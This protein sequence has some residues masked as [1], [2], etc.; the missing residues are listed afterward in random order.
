MYP[1]SARDGGGA[2]CPSS[3][4]ARGH[5]PSPTWR[6]S[7]P[8]RRRRRWTLVQWLLPPLLLLLL[9]CTPVAD[10]GRASRAAQRARHRS[11]RW[12]TGPWLPCVLEDGDCG[13]GWQGRSVRCVDARGHAVLERHCHRHVRPR[14]VQSCHTECDDGSGAAHRQSLRWQAGEWSACEE[15]NG[16]P[17]LRSQ[18]RPEARDAEGLA[19]RNVSCVFEPEA[20]SPRVVDAAACMHLLQPPSEMP[21][22]ISCP[23]DCV[24]TPFEAWPACHNVSG[25]ASCKADSVVRRRVVLVGPSNGG[26]ECPALSETKKCPARPGCR[27]WRKRKSRRK[28]PAADYVLRVGPWGECQSDYSILQRESLGSQDGSE[29]PVASRQAQLG[30]RRRKV[31]CLDGNG[32]LVDIG[33]CRQSDG[34][35]RPLPHD[36]ESCVV[37]VH[38]TVSPWS[39]WH[40][41]REGCQLDSGETWHGGQRLR[42]RMRYVQQLPYGAGRPCPPLVETALQQDRLPLCSSFNWAT[43]EWNACVPVPGTHCNGGTRHRNVTCV[44]TKDW[45]PVSSQLCSPQ[46]RPPLQ[47]ECRVPCPIDCEV[48]HWSPWGQCLPLIRGS[49]FPAPE[50][51]YRVRTRT[52]LTAPS[53]GGR[54]C[55]HLKEVESCDRA[56][57]SHWEPQPWGPCKPLSGGNCGD[58]IQMRDASC[59]FFDGTV[60]DDAHCIIY[61]SPIM[62]ERECTVPCADDCV[63]SDWSPWSPCSSPCAERMDYGIQ[64]RNRSILGHAGKGGASCPAKSDLREV[65]DCN[66]VR[67]FGM[68]WRTGP[69]KKCVAENVT[70]G[71]GRGRQNRTVNCFFK[72][73]VSD[74]KCAPLKKPANSQPCHIPCPVDCQVT[75]FSDWRLCKDCG[76]GAEPVLVRERFVLRRETPGGQPCPWQSLREVRLCRPTDGEAWCLLG[77]NSQLGR[78]PYRWSTSPWSQCVFAPDA[79]CGSGHQVRNVTCLD[80]NSI[81]VEPALCINLTSVVVSSRAPVLSAPAAHRVCH[82]RCHDQCAVSEWSPWSPCPEGDSANACD[83]DA[84]SRRTRQFIGVSSP[85]CLVSLTEERPCPPKQSVKVIN[86]PWS[87]CILQGEASCGTGYRLR[88]TSATAHACG[89]TGF[90]NV[91]CKEP[92]PVDCVM[93]EWSPWSRCDAV[94]GGGTRTRTRRV[95]RWHQY[96]GRPCPV[97]APNDMEIQTGTC[98]MDCGRNIWLP[99]GWTRC[100]PLNMSKKLPCGVEGFRTRS[101]LC[102]SVLNGDPYEELT[103]EECDPLRKPHD[104]EP[105]K[106]H[107]PGE[108]VVSEWSEWSSCLDPTTGAN[109]TERNRTRRVLRSQKHGRHCPY[110][111]VETDVCLKH[112]WELGAQGSCVVS[113]GSPCGGGVSKTPLYCVRDSDGLRVDYNYCDPKTKPS[114]K[115]L[116][117]PC[118][119]SCPI[120]CKVS[121]WSEWDQTECESCGTFVLVPGEQVRHRE[122]IQ[123]ATDSGRPCARSLTQRKPCAFTPCYYWSSGG[124]SQCE[125]HGADCGFGVRKRDVTCR[126]SDGV[127]VDNSFC[128][129]ANFT[130][131][132]GGLLGLDWLVVGNDVQTEEQCYVPCPQGCSLFPWSDWSPCNRNCDTG[133]ILGQTS[134]SRAVMTPSKTGESRY[135]PLEMVQTRPCWDG[136]CLTYSWRV[137]NGTLQCSRSDGL[138][139]E[140][141]GCAGRPRPCVPGCPAGARCDALTG[142]CSCLRG[143]VPVFVGPEDGAPL[144]SQ[145]QRETESSPSAAGGASGAGGGG[146]GVVVLGGGASSSAGAGAA[147]GSTLLARCEPI[148]TTMDGAGHAADNHTAAAAGD[149]LLKYYPDDNEYSFWMYAMISV[150]SA[151]VIFVAVTVYLMCHSSMRQR[152]KMSYSF[153]S[154]HRSNSSAASTG[155]VARSNA[156]CA[157]EPAPTSSSC[158][159][160]STT[161][162]Y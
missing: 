30:V 29:L 126:R 90:E 108:C 152:L 18:C 124:W 74:K 121:D 17:H 60:V 62:K 83:K 38:C 132:A 63:L 87:D 40:L 114:T 112:H 51:G 54:E 86:A 34:K 81:P 24:V 75:N 109:I 99:S 16:R 127:L 153:S 43:S 21:C 95:V 71:C 57:L 73:S 36:A 49:P 136:V 155:M 161:Q 5:A 134:R 143:T 76:D 58:G 100:R 31:A 106:L 102:M 147:G 118:N 9:L 55:P 6:T 101:I 160:V 142:Q 157:Y 128:H 84:V 80:S 22:A 39:P 25:F 37:P 41:E 113:D 151:F 122:V 156:C 146:G 115:H 150:G 135:C 72:G 64:S 149:I 104:N 12:V 92:C 26:A 2:P 20:G 35:Q 53:R 10:A 139:V 93:G 69:W 14:S 103:E 116:E 68:H 123:N 97:A 141:A 27:E 158:T 67:C 45:T 144:S 46:P 120:D 8:W 13:Q 33:K 28:A 98:L 125:L 148:R 110:H 19:R 32:V 94:C 140:G 117:T 138:I 77:R 162:L 145:P 82:V 154:R 48:S 15:V 85:N 50:E 56:V 23:Q 78:G 88:L 91:T 111:L 52:V 59:V 4:M 137:V 44:R 11:H 119:V 133:E 47:E 66:M 7:A 70:S 131:Y 1:C 79:R 129:L 42:R 61:E 89:S 130:S 65:D 96:R 3:G 105:C 159:A 107:C